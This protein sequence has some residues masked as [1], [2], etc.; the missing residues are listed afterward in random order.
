MANKWQSA[1]AVVEDAVVII[2]AGQKESTEI[3]LIGTTIMGLYIPAGFQG[4]RVF[5]KAAHSEGDPFVPV[6][7]MN[8]GELNLT[9]YTARMQAR[10]EY[11]SATAFL[12]ITTG[13]GGITLGG[14]AGTI[15]LLL[16]ATATAAITAE[17]GYYD[18]E[19][20]SPTGRVYRLL[21]G[22]ICVSKEATR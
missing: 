5:F 4:A 11:E 6:I 13:N 16:S 8:Q 3:D 22:K 2:P 7:V 20:V 14:A 10:E 1:A 19:L 17:H 15:A 21:Q 12:D 18:L 9:G